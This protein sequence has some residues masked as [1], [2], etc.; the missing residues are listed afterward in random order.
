MLENPALVLE[1]ADRHGARDMTQRG[2]AREELR[3]MIPRSSQDLPGLE[4]PEK[5]WMYR[6][7]K[8]YWFNDFG[9]YANPASTGLRKPAGEQAVSPRNDAKDFRN[10][11]DL[12]VDA[13]G[14]IH[15]I[16]LPKT[17]SNSVES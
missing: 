13:V 10:G 9:T 7:A 3:A 17:V 4:I 6:F 14:T 11:S 1:I 16:R 12:K 2:T 8:R 15:Q 5:H